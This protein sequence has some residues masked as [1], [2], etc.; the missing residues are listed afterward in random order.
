MSDS[1]RGGRKAVATEV[2]KMTL[3]LGT[4]KC[5]EDLVKLAR[6]GNTKAEV[7]AYLIMRGIEDMS[8]RG[9]LPPPTWN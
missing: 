5:L 3:P 2:V 8:T 4:A 1:K 6:F 9:M 7:A